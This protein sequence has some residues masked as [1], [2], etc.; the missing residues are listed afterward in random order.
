MYIALQCCTCF[1]R[2]PS[3]PLLPHPILAD[4]P[5]PISRSRRRLKGPNQIRNY[6]EPSRTVSDHPLSISGPTELAAL[7]PFH[8]SRCVN[9]VVHI[10]RTPNRRPE[11][12]VFI[13]TL[14]TQDLTPVVSPYHPPASTPPYQSCRLATPV[15]RSCL[16]LSWFSLPARTPSPPIPAMDPSNRRAAG[17]ESGR[18]GRTSAAGGEMD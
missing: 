18:G 11:L 2:P 12:R 8:H 13:I 16:V 4:T 7:H 17:G 14:D 15:V 5:S 10:Y 1:E 3:I 9:T 6:T